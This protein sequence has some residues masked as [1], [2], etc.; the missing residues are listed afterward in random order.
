MKVQFCLQELYNMK[1]I[2]FKKNNANQNN[3]ESQK[4]KKIAAADFIGLL[5]RKE[6]SAGPCLN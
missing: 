5:I 2:S 3:R 1:V 6:V 4:K